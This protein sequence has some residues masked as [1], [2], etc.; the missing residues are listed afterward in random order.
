MSGH[1]F[2]GGAA[3]VSFRDAAAREQLVVACAGTLARGE[4]RV[5]ETTR[6]DLAGIT[7]CFVATA[8]LRMAARGALDL[9]ASAESVLPDV[10]GG[11][12]GDTSIGSLLRHR[13]G[14]AAWGGLYLDV[15][16]DIGSAAARRWVISEAARRGSE[17]P[18]GRAER[19][20]LGYIVAAEAIARAAGS[21]LEEVIA[22]EVLKPLG[23]EDDVAY[24]SALGTEGRLAYTRISAPTERCQ[25]RGRLVRGDPQ[26]EN[27][28]ALGGVAGHA[29]LF[30]SAQ[31]VALFGRAVLDSLAGRSE[32][33]PA[34]TMAKA[35]ADAGDGSRLRLGWEA[36]GTTTVWGRR[37]SPRSFGQIG[38]T[39]TS[40][41][42]D[43]EKDV[44]VV[45][46]TNRI[47]PSRANEKIDGFRPAFHDGVL[48]TLA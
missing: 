3:C 9:D 48:A 32:L 29:G 36:K 22:Q 12:L 6:Y 35:L 27:A 10:R 23:I 11:V 18:A 41:V 4:G 28:A 38:F 13:G 44:V 16:H 33:L 15:P 42:C 7:Q 26:D 34:K 31:G 43:P 24:P 40:L 1:V 17:L 14:L 19:S 30:G 39:G 47:C 21:T 8:A 46:L 2:P 37:T 25:W 20:D 45:L 5:Q